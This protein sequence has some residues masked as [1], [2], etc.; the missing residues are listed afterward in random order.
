MKYRARVSS[1]IVKSSWC[2]VAARGESRG[3]DLVTALDEV[4]GPDILN[5]GQEPGLGPRAGAADAGKGIVDRHGVVVDVGQPVA[6]E[7]TPARTEAQVSPLP[8]ALPV[9]EAQARV[10]GGAVV[11]VVRGVEAVLRFRVLGNVL[12]LREV[13]E[14]VD[15]WVEQVLFDGDL[16]DIAVAD[17]V[18]EGD[19]R[20]VVVGVAA[21]GVPVPG[22]VRD[23]EA[24][25]PFLRRR[26][27]RVHGELLALDVF[28]AGALE[29]TRACG[30]RAHVRHDLVLV[31]QHLARAVAES[32]LGAPRHLEVVVVAVHLRV[33]DVEG[34]VPLLVRAPLQRGAGVDAFDV[35]EDD[36]L[37]D[38]AG[39]VAATAV[40][41]R[42]AG[43]AAPLER[44][45][46]G[47][48]GGPVEDLR[49]V[50]DDVEPVLARG[51]VVARHADQEA[52]RVVGE[53]VAVDAREAVTVLVGQGV[54]G[55]ER[56]ARDDPLSAVVE[57]APG[58]DVERA[59]HA[60]L[61][62]V[63]LRRLVHLDRLHQ[64]GLHGL[65]PEGPL[66]AVVA[67]VAGERLG[68]ARQCA[69]AIDQHARELRTETPDRNLGALAAH[70][71]DGDAGDAL[72][73]LGEVLVRE[74]ADVLGDE[75]VHDV[76]RVAFHVEGLAQAAADAGDDDFLDDGVVVP[77]L[78]E[79]ELYARKGAR[80]GQGASGREYCRAPRQAV[81]R[82]HAC[83]PF[84]SVAN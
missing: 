82:N 61:H 11:E 12:A 71:V 7:L 52:E 39:H 74:L 67:D 40:G 80:Q 20:N 45:A 76:V 79:G 9:A 63:G 60:A 50:A 27:L 15:G 38:V 59:A 30:L 46:G 70:A 2:A 34:D 64:F 57:R 26:V 78:G 75:R 6:P 55:H 3:R 18:R 36:A 28:D 68:A 21:E 48:V 62:E 19:G 14:L 72:Q 37:A 81:T 29:R 10:E 17:V 44:L 43:Q 83:S 84:L 65:E 77:L 73:R 33:Q 69:A 31:E 66:L 32:R 25:R 5:V 51:P 56:V 47:Q 49:P 13:D 41:V 24:E 4:G 1:V 35:L 58:A 22:G 53:R 42:D 16:R 23:I 54:V 8:E